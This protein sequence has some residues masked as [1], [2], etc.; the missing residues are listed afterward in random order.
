[1]QKII[2]ISWPI[3]FGMTSYKDAKPFAATPIA[4]FEKNGARDTNLLINT[5]TG[6]HVDA[7]SHFLKDGTSIDKIALGSLIGHTIV[8]DLTDITDCISAHHFKDDSFNADDIVLFKTKNSL[9]AWDAPF[10]YTFIYLD[11]SAALYL[12]DREV[13]A[14]GID[15]LGIER[16]QKNHP[17]HTLLL[18]NNIP[19]IEGLRLA[20][21]TPGRYDFYCLP[22]AVVGLEAAPARAILIQH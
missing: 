18:E 4:T 8:I 2:D 3:A 16:A 20:D 22:L 10:D 7:P 5:H 19:I 13:K 21:V 15:Y 11:E 12:I 1:M 14:V 6:T 9:R 17:T